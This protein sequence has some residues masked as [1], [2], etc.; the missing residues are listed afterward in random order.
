MS[1]VHVS[2]NH[3]KGDM[4]G[5]GEGKGGHFPKLYDFHLKT[6]VLNVYMTSNAY[7]TLLLQRLHISLVVV[8]ARVY[9]VCKLYNDYMGFVS[10]YTYFYCC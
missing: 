5:K 4:S 10:T 2:T 3:N 6:V 9:M 1:R 8:Q 7:N